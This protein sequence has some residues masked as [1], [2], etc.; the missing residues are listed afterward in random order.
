MLLTP[1]SAFDRTPAGPSAAQPLPILAR[2][3]AASRRGRTA[4]L[5]G[6]AL[7]ASLAG[8]CAEIVPATPDQINALAEKRA[9]MDEPAALVEYQK[10]RK[11]EVQAQGIDPDTLDDAAP[12]KLE[13]RWQ[14]FK[15]KH[16][17]I[18]L[19]KAQEEYKSLAANVASKCAF[20]AKD[21]DALDKCVKQV[22]EA[23]YDPI[24][25]MA[26]AVAALVGA[27][28][29]LLAFRFVRKRT[30]PVAQAGEKLRLAVQTSQKNT[31][32]TG[33]HAGY[34]IK[35]ET[36]APEVG[37]GDRF[38]R[39][40][41]LS[42]IAPNVVVRFGPLAPP[43]GL[44]LPDLD[45]PEIPDRRLPE[46]YKL[47]LSPGASVD[48]LLQGDLGFQLSSYDPI[49]VRVHDGICGVT[50]WQVPQSTEKVIEFIDMAMGVA[51]L[52]TKA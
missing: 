48:D 38:I 47:R 41:I 24:K 4:G 30:D 16:R 49:D 27:V 37:E 36:S 21:A 12:L 2:V 20:E 9:D 18:T 29:L 7:L 15:A 51:R 45:A 43:T 35:I 6:V 25:V 42:K 46:G 40:L 33:E 26:G 14:T 13:D 8:G 10:Q 3:A 34:S 5:A 1:R 22:P 50:C 28:A 11:K 23:T 19:Q 17:T 44:D 32:C 52:Y 31:V 39:V